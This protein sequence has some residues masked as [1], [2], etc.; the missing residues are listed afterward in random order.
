M[1]RIRAD[2]GSDVLYKVAW[3]ASK[4]LTRGV[5]A[6]M[7]AFDNLHWAIG[8]EIGPHAMGSPYDLQ[9]RPR[10]FSSGAPA[11]VASGLDDLILDRA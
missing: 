3:R 8:I 10:F 5:M 7:D 11:A 4:G 1:A 6:A 9:H 2:H